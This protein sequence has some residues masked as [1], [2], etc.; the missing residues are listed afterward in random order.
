MIKTGLLVATSKHR[1]WFYTTLP[2]KVD[3]GGAKMLFADSLAE[4]TRILET[5]TI[6]IVFSGAADS[7]HLE[8]VARIWTVSPTTCIHI[9]GKDMDPYLFVGGILQTFF[10]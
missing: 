10:A 5:E 8:I 1:D 3:F 6:D 7:F 2:N 4:V 9:K